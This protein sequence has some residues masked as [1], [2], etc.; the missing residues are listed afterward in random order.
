MKRIR[1]T[2]D[3][4]IPGYGLIRKGTEFDV[5]RYNKRFVYAIVHERVIL[6]LARKRDTEVVY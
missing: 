4:Q 2:H 6:R 1:V 5:D 3:M